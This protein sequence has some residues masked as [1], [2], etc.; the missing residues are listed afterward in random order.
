MKKTI[1]IKISKRKCIGAN[2][3]PAS[4]LIDIEGEINADTIYEAL[5]DKVRPVETFVIDDIKIL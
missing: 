5:K 1:F 2:W 4:F 3:Q